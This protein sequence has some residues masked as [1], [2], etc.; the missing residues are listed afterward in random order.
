VLSFA[1]ATGNLF[2]R[3]GRLGKL[4]SNLRT[5][6]LAQLSSMTNTTTGVVAQ[7]NAE[8][9]IQALMGQNYLS[10]LAGVESVGSTASDIAIT[11]LNRMIFRDNPRISQTLEGVNITDSL[12]ELIRQMRV[13]GASILAATVTATPS[14]FTGAGNGVVVASVKRPSDGLTLENAY[15]ENLLITC[16]QDSYGG[17]ATEG[18]E[19]FTITGTGSQG[20]LF[21]FNWPLGSNGQLSENAIDGNVDNGSGNI[22][23]NSGFNTFTVANTPDNWEIVTGTPGT[24]IFEESTIVFDGAKALRILGDG[25]ANVEWRQKFDDSTGTNG[26][27]SNLSQYAFNMWLRRD[28]VAAAAGVLT[29]SLVDENDDVVQDA[30]GVDNSFTIDLTA[31]STVYT[32]YTGVFRTPL[33]MPDELYLSMK[34][35]TPLTTGRSVYLDKA[36]LGLTQQVYRNGPYLSVFSGAVPFERG[37][38]TTTAITNSRGAAGTLDTFQT[39]LA[40]LFPEVLAN[41][42]LFPSSSVPTISDTLITN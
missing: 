36:G 38:Y 26:A 9:D 27:L 2:N 3:L 33:I 34:I 19:G 37:D 32:S 7:Y 35:T 16:T 4:L 25:T 40:R 42:Y 31:L 18:N 5:H 21:A 11:T 17:G 10:I 23:T 1:D 29:I 12:N 13:Q 30:A 41:E 20:D 39:L 22:L 15:A 6:Q 8:S 28:G 24:N 14:A